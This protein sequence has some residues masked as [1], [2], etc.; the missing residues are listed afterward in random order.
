MTEAP[1]VSPARHSQ[2]QIQHNLPVNVLFL[3]NGSEGWIRGS[4]NAL[5]T[6]LRNADRNRIA[7]SLLTS[8]DLLAGQA[9]SYGID[10]AVW[11]MPEV[12]IDGTYR[13]LQIGRW[14]KDVLRIRSLVKRKDVDLLYCNGGSTHQVGYYAGKLAGIPVISHIHSPY[15]RR[16]ILLYRL[17]RASRVIAVSKAVQR[18]LAGKQAFRSTQDVVYNGVDTEHFQPAARTDPSLKH[19]LGLPAD[20]LVFGQVSSLIP[21]KGIDVLLNAFRIASLRNPAIRLVLVGDGPQS[22]TY[23][24]MAAELEISDKVIFA[25][26]Q[27]DPLP[28]YQHVFDAHILASRSDAFPLTLLEAASCG[29]PNIGADVDGIGE[30]IVDSK[31]GFLF[32][33]ERYDVL[34]GKMNLLVEQIDLRRQL[35]EAARK[36]AVTRFSVQQYCRSIERIILKETARTEFLQRNQHCSNGS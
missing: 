25:G 6:L 29:L 20:S 1:S 15:N 11:R 13:R 2:T 18:N 9:A 30:A 35:G 28:F 3:H 5:L 26:N 23:V 22:A 16:Y 14:F 24:K 17:H 27:P 7:P 21:R 12:M 4:E 19:K 36:L 34:A 32:Q 31:T 33:S 8:N 10:A